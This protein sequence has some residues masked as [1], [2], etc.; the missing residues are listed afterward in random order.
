MSKI[1]VS[2]LTDLGKYYEENQDCILVGN[3]IITDGY[4]ASE[5]NEPFISIVCDGTGSSKN[6]KEASRF[7]TDYIKG[8]DLNVD[9]SEE[10][11]KN[12]LLSCNKELFNSF[13][14]GLSTIVG[15]V[16]KDNE[17]F[18]FN[19]GDSRAHIIK[20][21]TMMQLSKDDTFGNE[22]KE[23][24]LVKEVSESTKL[25]TKLMGYQDI[26]LDD[27]DIFKGNMFF[28]KNLTF[29]LSS[30]GLTDYVEEDIIEEILLSNIS[31]EDKIK[32]L[33]QKAMENDSKDNISIILIN[34]GG[35]SDE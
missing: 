7:I 20:N 17:Y 9:L 27:F 19:L 35:E 28:N 12:Y 34:I 23:K 26:E 6:A 18:I 29:L 3:E 14:N 13:E 31:Y 1:V 25:V 30:D 8:I 24:G 4:Y 2:A 33:Y 16:I 22:L 15:I 10:Y 11:L 32:S 5:Y 21:Q